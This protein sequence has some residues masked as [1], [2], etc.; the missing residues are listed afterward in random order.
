MEKISIKGSTFN[1]TLR[2]MDPHMQDQRVRDN[3]GHLSEIE[4]TVTGIPFLF[5]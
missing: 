5:R 4:T 3:T 2:E 1:I